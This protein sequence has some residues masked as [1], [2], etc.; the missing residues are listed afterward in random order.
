MSMLELRHY[1][2]SHRRLKE[3]LERES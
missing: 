3:I 2:Q 1:T